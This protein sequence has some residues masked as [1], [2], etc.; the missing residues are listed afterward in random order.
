MQLLNNIKKYFQLKALQK[1]HSFKKTKLQKY[2]ATSPQAADAA[3]RN[4]LAQRLDNR[5]DQA[6]IDIDELKANSLIIKIISIVV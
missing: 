4:G 5:T 1:D 6:Q 3:R 2:M